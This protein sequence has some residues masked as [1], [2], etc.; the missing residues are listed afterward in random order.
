[1]AQTFPVSPEAI[2]DALIGDTAF[3]SYLGTYKFSSNGSTDPSI[4]VISPG[5]NLPQL[6]NVQ[7]LECVIHDAATIARRDYVSGTS[8]LVATW[9]VY[10]ICWPPSNGNDMTVATK[11]AMEIFG[12]ATSIET[13][14]VSS[15]L[16]ALAQTLISIPEDTP[17]LIEPPVIP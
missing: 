15:G 6:R 9:N 5:Q 3:A 17:I 16:G 4:S 7:G 13:V 14:A 2:Y 8:D 10:L 1:M 11:R 12:G